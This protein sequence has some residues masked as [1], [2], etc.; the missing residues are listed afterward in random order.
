MIHQRAG[1][2][3]KFQTQMTSFWVQVSAN[4]FISFMSTAQVPKLCN[5]S[6]LFQFF[7]SKT[8]HLAQCVPKDKELSSCWGGKVW[9]ALLASLRAV[10]K[11]F[12]NTTEIHDHK[13]RSRKT[14]TA[15]N[16]SP[17][18][19]VSLSNSTVPLSNQ[20]LEITSVERTVHA[21]CISAVPTD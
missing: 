16:N 17:D 9:S 14:L 19:L 8:V 12:N 13:R 18:F 20:L 10:G 11:D 5:L 3:L 4:P 21:R 7:F 2:G 15:T 6:F 1:K